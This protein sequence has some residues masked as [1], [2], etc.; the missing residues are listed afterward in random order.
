MKHDT[1]C[2]EVR[3]CSPISVHFEDNSS[4]ATVPVACPFALVLNMCT[5]AE[6]SCGNRQRLESTVQVDCKWLHCLQM[7][8]AK[9]SHTHLTH[10]ACI[11]HLPFVPAM[12]HIPHSDI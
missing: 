7:I 9:A 4:A 6:V 10:S 2:T 12:M 11:E 3:G 1:A 8:R 5:G